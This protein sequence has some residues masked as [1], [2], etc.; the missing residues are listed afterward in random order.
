MREKTIEGGQLVVVEGTS[1]VG[2]TTVIQNLR[3]RQVVDDWYLTRE[4]GGTE[5]G[6]RIRWAVQDPDSKDVHPLAALMAYA[7]SRANLVNLEIKP[8]LESGVNCL[9]DRWWF[10]TWAYQGAEGVS[11]LT[12]WLVNMIAIRG[13]QP[14]LTL[15]YDLP[16]DVGIERK[17]RCDDVD[18]YDQKEREFMQ[19]ARENYLQLRLFYPRSWETINTTD[20]NPNEVVDETIG[21]LRRRRLI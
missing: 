6:D 5:F 10:S 18:R 21:I 15:F 2:K 19:S 8:R 14:D 16:V 1:G 7:A 12:I 9:I 11:K 20:K 13:Q 17:A 4:P 3:E